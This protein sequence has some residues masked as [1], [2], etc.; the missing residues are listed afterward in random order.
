MRSVRMLL[1]IVLLIIMGSG[2]VF[3]QSGPGCPGITRVAGNVIRI[4]TTRGKPGDTVLVPCIVTNTDP[5]TGASIVIQIDTTNILFLCG[6][7]FVGLEKL[8]EQRIGGKT[9]GFGAD[10]KS[11]KDREL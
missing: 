9:I 6:G 3:A 1:L 10:I 4:D 7:A 8:I 2:M 5:F 11:H